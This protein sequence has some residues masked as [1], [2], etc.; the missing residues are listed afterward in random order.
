MRYVKAIMHRLCSV[1]HCIWV[2]IIH[3]SSFDFCMEEIIASSTHFSIQDNGRI[4]IGNKCGMRRNC[5]LMVSE[6]GRIVL[7]DRVFLNKGCVLAAHESITIGN[8]T[9]LGPGVMIFDHDYDYKKIDVDARNN[10]ISMPISIG[11][12]VWIGAGTVI[13][14]GTTIGDNCVVG[15][16]CVIKGNF[17]NDSLIVQK[18]EPKVYEIERM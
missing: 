7:G 9:R 15:A 13:L 18:R 10:H 12:N 5:E 2:K 6:N 3:P 16:G 14:K 1:I 8:G 4:S 17:E 11:E